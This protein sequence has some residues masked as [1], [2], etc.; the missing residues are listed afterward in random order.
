MASGR[1][2]IHHIH[3]VLT[4]GVVAGIAAMPSITTIQQAMH[5]DALTDMELTTVATRSNPPTRP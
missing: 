4:C 3:H 5:L 2:S 1:Q